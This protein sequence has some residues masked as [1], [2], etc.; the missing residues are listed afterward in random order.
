MGYSDGAFDGH[1]VGN[2]L[3]ELGKLVGNVVG[4][5]HP[6]L[7]DEPQPSHGSFA[8]HPPQSKQSVPGKQSPYSFPAPPSSQSLSDGWWHSLVQMTF[9]LSVGALV[10]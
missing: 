7:H 8:G 4:S 2:T 9:S 3:G 1:E 5:T 10:G 6:P